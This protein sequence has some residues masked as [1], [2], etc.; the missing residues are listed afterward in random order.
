MTVQTI[1]ELESWLSTRAVSWRLDPA[2]PIGAID[3]LAGLSN[4]ARLEPLDE[5]TVERYAADMADGAVFPPVVLADDGSGALEPVGGNHRIAAALRAERSTIPAYVVSTSDARVL[6][7]LALEDNR[8]HGRPLTTRER[9]HHALRLVEQGYTATEAGRTVGVP[10]STLVRH[11]SA[12][13]ADKRAADLGVDPAG[14]EDLSVSTRARL[15]AIEADRV[16]AK[17]AAMCAAGTI[18]GAEIGGLVGR[19]N[20][21]DTGAE[22]MQLLVDLENAAKELTRRGRGRPPARARAPRARLL[23]DLYQLLRNDIDSVAIDHSGRDSESVR[24]QI[25]LAQ[26][27]LDLILEALDTEEGR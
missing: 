19:L 9:L 16:F 7:L 14:W 8:R 10:A 21:A 11:G 1:P 12:E 17:T 23:G 24:N 6:W 18:T 15:D 22:A 13:K 3:Q 27:H 25:R 5:A 4:Q 26:R 20:A 2:V